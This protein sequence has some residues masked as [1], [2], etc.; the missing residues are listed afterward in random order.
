MTRQALIFDSG[1]GGLSVSAHIA[2]H[3]PDMRLIYAA[4][5]AFRPYGNKSQDQLKARLPG[6]LRTLELAIEPDVIVIAC[7]TASTAALPD[8]RKMCR[9][10]I[11]GVVPAI[12]P[13]A[14]L[15]QAQAIGVL[16]TPGTI[17]RDYV[18]GL[19]R[20]FASACEVTL[21]GST[22]LVEMAERKLAGEPVDMSA[23]AQEISPLFTSHSAPDIIV[24]A[25]THFPLLADELSRAAP[26]GVSF[27]DSGEAIA[28]RVK[29]LLA[30]EELPRSA[31]GRAQGAQNLR[32]VN[33]ALVIGTDK[34][35]GEGRAARRESFARFGYH[36]LVALPDLGPPDMSRQI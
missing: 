16:G 8:I 10:P 28:R 4:D 3:L 33:T 34:M 23:L 35:G 30:S 36:R 31:A 13:A 6:L 20:D 14:Q 22:A 5:D 26:K 9:A 32:E 11:V 24:L 27:I 15:S 29:S 1:I 18:G 2:A 12:K 7:N 25:C 19:I 21:H 17:S